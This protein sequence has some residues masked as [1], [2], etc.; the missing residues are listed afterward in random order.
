MHAGSGEGEGARFALTHAP[1]HHAQ[2]NANNSATGTAGLTV[3]LVRLQ[4]RRDRVVVALRHKV[5][6]RETRRLHARMGE[7]G[8]V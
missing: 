5:G 3:K 1:T 8:C 2:S 7:R 6:P 4:P